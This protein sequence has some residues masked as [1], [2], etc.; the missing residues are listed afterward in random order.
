MY[1][2]RSAN[3]TGEVTQVITL[4]ESRQLGLVAESDINQPLHTGI[5]KSGEKPFSGGLAAPDSH[6]T[7]GG[8][9]VHGTPPL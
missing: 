3:H 9:I 5:G 6:Q 4:A 8:V 7:D 2:L 1:I